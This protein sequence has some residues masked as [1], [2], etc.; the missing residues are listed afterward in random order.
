[1]INKPKFKFVE[2]YKTNDKAK[3]HKAIDKAVSKIANTH[4]EKSVK[5]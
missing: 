1:M 3:L 2:H 4:K 5:C